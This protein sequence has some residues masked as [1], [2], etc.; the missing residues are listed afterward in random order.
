MKI[1]EIYKCPIY[2]NICR[3]YLFPNDKLYA[4]F[5][6]TGDKNIKKDKF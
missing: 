4:G 1:N 5:S 6:V 3:K 2:R